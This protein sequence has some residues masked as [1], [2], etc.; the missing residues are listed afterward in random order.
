VNTRG[1]SFGA[2]VEMYISNS[3]EKGVAREGS[4]LLH[5]DHCFLDTF[6]PAICL[7]GEEV[8]RTGGATIFADARRA[9][10][11]LPQEI[12]DRLSS[13]EALHVY[14]YADDYG[15]QRFRVATASPEALRATH[16]VV[17]EHPETG[18][19]ILYVNRLMTDSIVGL[20]EDASER[21]LD[22][23]MTYFEGPDVRYE[24]TWQLHD[25]VVWDNVS[26]QHGRTEFPPTERRCLRRVQI[27]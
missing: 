19:P 18:R 14:D 15:N 4:L 9:Y 23:L 13:L 7:Y 26:L 2:D 25:L 3:H 21:L 1:Y 16:P 10:D 22:E 12:R 17:V 11:R 24:H 20:D 27:G 6:L 8:A 5:Q